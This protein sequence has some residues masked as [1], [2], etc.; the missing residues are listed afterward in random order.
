MGSERAAARVPICS[1]VTPLTCSQPSTVDV[2]AAWTPHTNRT[3][4]E[5][6]PKIRLVA[7]WRVSTTDQRTGHAR[8]DDGVM[9]FMPI[10]LACAALA[11]FAVGAL[12]GASI[13]ESDHRRR[14]AA[15]AELCELLD[16]SLP[17]STGRAVERHR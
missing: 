13:V 3:L 12:F 4:L 9:S 5:R 1:G 7:W 17:G 11:I 8:G 15:R 10:L 16:E 14:K 6:N 2:V